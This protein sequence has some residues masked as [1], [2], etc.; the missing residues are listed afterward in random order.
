M[1]EKDEKPLFTVGTLLLPNEYQ[2]ANGKP[3]TGIILEVKERDLW[4]HNYRV[5]LIPQG[6]AKWLEHDTILNLFKVIE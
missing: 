3:A 2:I 1:K 6:F 4:D 5:F